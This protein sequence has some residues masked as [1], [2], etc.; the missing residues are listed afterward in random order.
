MT[1]RIYQYLSYSLII[2]CGFS[3][4]LAESKTVFFD[5]EFTLS[6][7]ESVQVEGGLGFIKIIKVLEDS[8]CPVDVTCV[9]AGNVK[10]ELEIMD[11]DRKKI[12][13][14][15]NTGV[16]PNKLSLQGYALQLISIL[17]P[18]VEGV[19]ISPEQFQVKLRITDFNNLPK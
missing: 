4:A 12:S 5:K 15:L 1:N 16:K 14:F 8:R 7:G 18:K 17:P 13:I 3:Y 11:S 2:F 10:I 9:W 19:S 6:I